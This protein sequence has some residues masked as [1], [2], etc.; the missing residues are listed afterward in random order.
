MAVSAKLYTNAMK[1]FMTGAVTWKASGGSTIKCALVADTYTPNQDTHDN[2]DDV[3]SHEV[4]GT[5]YT[6]GGA[7]LTLSDPTVDT[8]TNEIGMDATDVQW[9]NSTI[10]ARYAVIYFA[11][12]T[13]STSTLI[14]YVDFGEDMSSSSGTFSI[15]WAATGVFKVTVS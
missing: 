8:A 5:G 2:W 12:G 7:T 10:I 9:T 13:P 3:S 15:V 6:T 14:G 11:S 4:S 1:A